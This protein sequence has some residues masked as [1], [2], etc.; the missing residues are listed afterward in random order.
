MIN[1]FIERLYEFNVNLDRGIQEVKI[2][3]DEA[4]RKYE[5]IYSNLSSIR[6]NEV[7]KSQW[8]EHL[9]NLERNKKMLEEKLN[10]MS[11]IKNMLCEFFPELL[12]EEIP[13]EQ[14]E[15]NTTN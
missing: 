3:Y 2:I 7:S 1:N 15:T 11:S 9:S 5:S 13:T 12:K 14:K 4:V 10:Y 6:Y 8:N